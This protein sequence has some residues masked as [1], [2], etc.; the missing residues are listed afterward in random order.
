MLD[1][2]VHVFVAD[3]I[4]FDCVAN[5]AGNRCGALLVLH[6]GFRRLGESGDK[7][8]KV[9]KRRVENRDDA[10]YQQRKK[11][12]KNTRQSNKTI[13]QY[14]QMRKGKDGDIFI[15]ITIGELSYFLTTSSLTLSAPLPQDPQRTPTI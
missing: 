1:Y 6:R 5:I 14:Q 11:K 4:A 3:A 7:V 8:L 15:S 2:T 13:K 12:S 10:H 9:P